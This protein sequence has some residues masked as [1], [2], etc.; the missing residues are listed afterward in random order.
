LRILDSKNPALQE[1]ILGA[2]KLIDHLGSES[3]AHFEGVQQVLRDA[4]QPSRSTRAWCA[5]ST[6]TT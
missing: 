3:M 6:T 5:A 2:P 4:G 1:L